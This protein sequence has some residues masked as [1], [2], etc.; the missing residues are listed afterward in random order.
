MGFSFRF[1]GR[2]RET[3]HKRKRSQY[4]LV[5]QGNGYTQRSD[6]G[7]Y[8]SGESMSLNGPYRIQGQTGSNRL[9]IQSGKGPHARPLMRD[10]KK[11]K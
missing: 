3:L 2:E 4:V 8:D 9:R 11:N 6:I 5:A 7:A 1:V 10:D